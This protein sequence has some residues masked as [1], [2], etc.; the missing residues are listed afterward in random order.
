MFE[1]VVLAFVGSALLLTLGSAACRLALHWRYGPD[2]P[3]GVQ[4]LADI[5]TSVYTTGASVL[6]AP[7]KLFVYSKASETSNPATPAAPLLPPS[8]TKQIKKQTE[9]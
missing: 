7:F 5:F 3:A 1:T 2:L 4:S 8:E 9:A 6:L